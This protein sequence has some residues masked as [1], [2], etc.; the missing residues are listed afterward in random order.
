MN[1][2]KCSRPRSS[3][4][5]HD[6]SSN[7][8]VDTKDKAETK[9]Y[10]NNLG[11]M[12]AKKRGRP[13]KQTPSSSTSIQ[14]RSTVAQRDH[15]SLD[16]SLLDDQI[17][18]FKGLENLDSKQA[19]TL[20][21]NVDAL[22]DKIKGKSHASPEIEVVNETQME[23]ET[24]PN[25]NEKDQQIDNGVPP[26]SDQEIGKPIP[27]SEGIEAEGIEIIQQNDKEKWQVVT[28]RQRARGN[29]LIHNLVQ[30]EYG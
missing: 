29:K 19:K 8:K 17:L 18:N 9:K 7:Q 22:R 26:T 10:P 30:P 11:S 1:D 6:K 5:D 16:F 20:L 27:E 28:T 15:I 21:S 2:N 23:N 12:M 4:P 13:S 25:N 3:S 14:E 24:T